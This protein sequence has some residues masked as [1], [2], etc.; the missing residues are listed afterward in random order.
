MIDEIYNEFF[1]DNQTERA[2]DNSEVWKSY[3][4]NELR[5]DEIRKRASLEYKIDEENKIMNEIN[6]FRQRIEVNPKLK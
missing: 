5:R 2:L 4:N 3:F 1:A 6:D